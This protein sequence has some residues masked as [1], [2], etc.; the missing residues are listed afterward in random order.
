MYE[1]SCI[2]EWD[3]ETISVPRNP[4][5]CLGKSVCKIDKKGL[6]VCSVTI[7]SFVFVNSDMPD[8]PSRVIK[9]AP[10]RGQDPPPIGREVRRFNIPTEYLSIVLFIGHYLLPEP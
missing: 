10:G 3:V 9:I 4:N 6:V 8:S 2:D 1:Q 5:V 7:E